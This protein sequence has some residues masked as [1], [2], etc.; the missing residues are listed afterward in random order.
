MSRQKPQTEI[1]VA[2]QILSYFLR[3]PQAADS[4]EGVARWR[5]LDER[6]H[7][8]FEETDRALN[9]L[10][11]RGFLTED[12]TPLSGR[13]FR[14]NVEKRSEAEHFLTQLRSRGFESSKA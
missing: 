9:Y 10:V 4:L 8:A 2:S 7:H 11:S 5:L 3:N 12:S 6:V 13:I 1:G 14:L